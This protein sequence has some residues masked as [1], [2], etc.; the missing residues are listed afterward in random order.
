M[1]DKISIRGACQNNLKNLDLD[2]ELGKITVVTGVSGSGKSSL[3]F[4]TVY[5]EGQRRYIESFSAYARQFMDRMDKPAVDSIEG[6]LPAIAINQTN[7]I[8]TSRSTLGTLTEI[9]DYMKLLFPRLARLYC[10][11]CGRVVEKDSADSICRVLMADHADLA[12]SIT[13]PF[14]VPPASVVPLQEVEAGLRAQGFYRI[15]DAGTAKEISAELLAQHAEGT[16][17]ILSDRVTIAPRNKKRLADSL[18]TTLK[19]GKGQASVFL[20][21]ADAAPLKFS[22]DLH[23]PHCD[24]HYRMPS[25]GLFSFNSPLG[26]CDLCRGFGRTIEV[27]LDAVVPDTSLSLK[28]DAIKPWSTPS[29]RE[30]YH[31]LLRFCRKHGIPADLPYRELT[32][33]QR[34]AIVNGSDDFYGIMGFF[35]WL[36]TRTYKMHIRVLLSKYRAYTLCSSCG[37]TR[38][39]NE[40]LLYKIGD[41]SIADVCSMPISGCLKYFLALQAQPGADKT[42]TVLLQEIASRLSYLER[43]GLGYLT[44]DRQSRTLSGG[45]VE[46][47]SLTTAL[48]SCLVNTLYVLDEPSIGLHPRDTRMLIEILKGL[49]DMGNTLMIVE[50]D[51]DII[52]HSDTVI[53]MG[54][55]SG[56]QGGSIVFTGTPAGLLKS[57]AS[58]TGKYMSG[59]LAIRP[60]RLRR[61]PSPDYRLQ[62]RGAA[63]HNLKSLDITIPLG[64][65]VC[66]TGVSGSGKSTFLE[67]VLY[68]TLSRRDKKSVLCCF[69]GKNAPE[70]VILMDQGPIGRTPRSNPVTYMKTFEAIRTLFAQTDAARERGYTASTFSFNSQG[71]RCQQC[72]GDGYEMVEMQFLADVYVTCPACRGRRYSPEVLEVTWQGKTIHDVL[73]MTV[74]EGCAFFADT[75]KVTSPLRILDMVG[76]GYLRLGQPA[77]TLSGGESQRLKLASFIRQGSQ[78]RTLFLFDEPTT[79]LHYDDIAKLLQAFDYLVRQGH[80]I[81]VVEHNLDI[82]KCADH[83]L[84]LGPEGGQAGGSIVAQG[85][86]DEIMAAADSYTGRFLK[87]YVLTATAVQRSRKKQAPR[88]GNTCIAIEGAREH[89]L[90]NL[91]LKVPLGQMVVITGLSGSGKSTLAFDILFAE[92]Q[93]RFLETLSPYARQYITQV[94]RPDVDAIRGLPP[95]VAIE[96]M[97]SRGGRNSTVATATEIYHYLRLLFAKAGQQ[98]CPGCGRPLAAQSPQDICRDIARSFG[99]RKVMLLAPQV[100]GRKGFHK[101]IIQRARLEGCSRIRIDGSV[102][103]VGNIFAV[104]RYHEHKID[105]I[106]AE[107]APAALSAPR[108]QDIIN[109]ALGLGRGEMMVLSPQGDEKF[110]SIKASCPECHVS[111]EEPDPR[112]FSFNSPSGACPRCEGLGTVAALSVE[113]MIADRQ[114]SIHDG[115]IPALIAQQVPQAL[116]KRIIGRIERSLGIAPDE[117][118]ARLTP[119]KY[120]ALLHGSKSFPGLA[121]LFDSPR[122]GDDSQLQDYLAQFHI[123]SSCPDCCGTRLNQAA[124]SVLIRDK[125]I[126]ELAAMTAPGLLAFLKTL[127]F[128]GKH[129]AIARPILQELVPKLQLLDKAGLSY[130]SLDR[131]ADT[132]SGGEAQRMRLAAQVASNLRGVA[133]VLDE[134]TI[135]LHPHDSKKLIAII[136]ELQQKGNS[137]IIVEH[138]EEMIRNADYIVDLGPGGGMHGGSVVAAGTLAEILKNPASITGAWLSETARHAEA[139]TSRPL[140][141][142]AHI[143]LVGAREHNL[144]DLTVAIPLGRLTVVTGI[145]GSGKTT[146][147]RETLYKGLRKKLGQYFGSTGSH[148][149][150]A[151]AEQV[152]RVVEIDQSPIGKTPRS[153]PATYVGFYDDIRKLYALVPDARMRGYAASRFS[154]NVSGGRCEK[155]SGQ[156]KLR[157]AM[158]F[159]PDMYVDCDECRG[160]RFND[161]TGQILLKGKNISQV[162]SMTVEEG[163]DFFTGFSAIHRPLD[164]LQRMGLGYLQL[165]Q[166]SPTLS[167]GEAQRIKIAAEL[168]KNDH[169]TTLY[170]LDEPTTGLHPADIEK[171]MS[172][173]QELVELGN[174]M[175]IIE[176]NLD[177]IGQ[178]DTIIDLG[179]GGGAD[180]G[181]ITAAGSPDDVASGNFRESLT[182]QYLREYRS[183]PAANRA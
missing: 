2:L 163:R 174:T 149:D 127:S 179:P 139:R 138:D 148:R 34:S 47:A 72:Q 45:E 77:N 36:E 121:A 164:I 105:F 18:E 63:T 158:N 104:K 171:L 58:L 86:P 109:R 57:T 9:A 51:H 133:Y 39:K 32:D 153:V 66:I 54:P 37:G 83:L 61:R 55:A 11:G 74:S 6:I 110:Y 124:R 79:G 3:A 90:K 131:S 26:A 166:P 117:P 176:H 49:R 73:E 4:D 181:R 120:K 98:H 81:I 97:L 76:L 145:S 102:V 10:R 82:I 108:L 173:L 156:G 137:V 132:L 84:D 112:L 1:D 101:D 59:A 71:G 128:S 159:L 80:S 38:F 111:M 48:G 169:G 96:Q 177:V 116:K 43:V 167:G 162:L 5:A 46:R 42:V 70:N 52:T 141:G 64:L 103:E 60:P 30:A 119:A 175:V 100:R 35:K 27:D 87:E 29:Y 107:C 130:L 126:A 106:T 155:C 23:C 17:N 143:T 170:V 91:S 40:T 21:G 92:G 129:R 8:K 14:T 160:N 165:G 113:L 150:I 157:I 94:A 20:Q 168:C 161:E 88:N 172:V 31:D 122:A 44:L 118:L 178:A 68:N 95:T 93:R 50:H 115:A 142:C 22:T 144:Q 78:G 125:S 151:G 75:P 180:G 152:R 114:H 41:A 99:S 12:C 62:V 136:R 33:E 123:E 140:A 183:R 65:L 154:F 19:F 56:E 24:I 69:E 7:A 182:A 28:G 15:F 85:T 147:V 134:P 25:P 16:V 13:F 89:N 146:L 135:G 53:D 67:D